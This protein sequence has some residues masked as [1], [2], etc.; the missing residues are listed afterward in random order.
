MIPSSVGPPIGARVKKGRRDRYSSFVAL[1]R[2][3]LFKCESWRRLSA[4]AKIFY[5]YL[6]AGY[7][8]QNNGQIQLHF[9][10]LSDLPE[11]RSRK[12][13]YGAARELEAAGWI[14]RTTPGGLFRNPNTYLLT[15][16][17]DGML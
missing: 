16:Q 17:F 7:N 4:R 14:K 5:L 8:G 6:K 2:R 13:F 3:V 12:S 11:L 1:E 9:G 15:G 10:A